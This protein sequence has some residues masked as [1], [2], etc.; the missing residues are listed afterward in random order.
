MSPGVAFKV[1]K[2]LADR[3][4]K[5]DII[6]QS[7]GRENTKDISFTVSKYDKDA[8]LEALLLNK[9]KV[10]FEDISVSENLCKVTI[11][12]SGM[13]KNSGFASMVFEALYEKN[14]EIHMISTSEISISV[15]VD[16]ALAETAEQAI[17]KRIFML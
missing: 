4:I 3:N 6:L 16:S 5:V 2:P 17:Y 10:D 14:I 15:L 1:F 12:G 13:L 7:V 11:S 9:E 8:V